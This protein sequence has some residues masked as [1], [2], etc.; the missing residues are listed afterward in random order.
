[1]M[2]VLLQINRANGLIASD[3]HTLL[4]A[5]LFGEGE[6]QQIEVVGTPGLSARRL[7]IQL[8]TLFFKSMF[9]FGGVA[10]YQ[11]GSL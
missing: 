4:H 7:N 10:I 11:E 6:D 3:S 9:I 1:M 5:L 8:F 2:G